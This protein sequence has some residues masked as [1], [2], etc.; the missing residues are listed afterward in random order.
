MAE[1]PGSEGGVNEVHDCVAPTC[2]RTS[3]VILIAQEDGRLGSR[4]YRTG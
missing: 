4:E 2:D 3:M 1:R